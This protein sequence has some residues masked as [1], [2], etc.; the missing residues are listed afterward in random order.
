M[1]YGTNKTHRHK[2]K[3]TCNKW[4]E[5]RQPKSRD[6]FSPNHK[7]MNTVFPAGLADPAFLSFITQDTQN[8]TENLDGT[9]NFKF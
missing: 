9:V 4:E 1:I 5:N 3:N 8:T 6:D 2:I 7:S